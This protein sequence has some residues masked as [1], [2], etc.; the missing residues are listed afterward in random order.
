MLIAEATSLH[1]FNLIW[2]Q[3]VHPIRPDFNLRNPC[4]FDIYL[5]N[6]IGLVSQGLLSR[7]GNVQPGIVQQKISQP[8]IDRQ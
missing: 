5:I 6:V 1:N 3:Y 8:G 4:S 7:G 2:C